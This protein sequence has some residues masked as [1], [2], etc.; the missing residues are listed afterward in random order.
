MDPRVK[1]VG[2]GKC[3]IVEN[4]THCKACYLR[5]IRTYKDRI[6]TDKEDEWSCVRNYREDP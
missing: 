6:A 1:Y 2:V 5:N 3:R 4:L